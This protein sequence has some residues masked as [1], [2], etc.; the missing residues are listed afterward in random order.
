MLQTEPAHIDTLAQFD[1]KLTSFGTLFAA[2]WVTP[3]TGGP[4]RACGTSPAA[5]P[6]RETCWRRRIRW[7]PKCV[8]EFSNPQ[9]VDRRHRARSRARRQLVVQGRVSLHGF[10]GSKNY[11]TALITDDGDL[12]GTNV[13]NVDLKIHTVRIRVSIT[14]SAA[15]A[16]ALTNFS[17]PPVQ[18][19]PPALQARAQKNALQYR[20][21][22]RSWTRRRTAEP[23]V[24]R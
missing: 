9:R 2:A 1:Q 10:L 21:A 15:M 8:D 19:G 12:P 5:G 23:N 7:Q 16:T 17:N 14:A 3:G 20:P 13:A 4:R 18:I 6:G 22:T 24:W 11:A